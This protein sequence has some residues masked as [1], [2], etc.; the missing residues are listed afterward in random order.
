MSTLRA[1]LKLCCASSQQLVSFYS[2]P[3]WSVLHLRSVPQI[4]VA[5]EELARHQDAPFFSSIS[6]YISAQDS[7]ASQDLEERTEHLLKPIRDALRMHLDALVM[8][9]TE[10]PDLSLTLCIKWWF[11]L[12]ASFCGCTR[13]YSYSSMALFS[14]FTCSFKAV[15]SFEASGIVSWKCRNPCQNQPTKNKAVIKI[16]FHSSPI[17]KYSAEP[18]AA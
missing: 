17:S 12:H 18:R 1:S 16:N 9:I 8:V 6:T 7:E 14:F 3:R 4:P 11:L 10:N 5:A 2:S 15:F 13:A